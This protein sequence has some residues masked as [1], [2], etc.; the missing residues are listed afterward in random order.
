MNIETGTDFSIYIT[1][2]N[3]MFAS[4]VN[5]SGQCGIGSSKPQ[6]MAMIDYESQL[7]SLDPNSNCEII[8]IHSNDNSTI[9]RTSEGKLYGFGNHSYGC[10]GL[11]E[12][13][14]RENHEICRVGSGSKE[15]MKEKCISFSCGMFF[16]C[17]ITES[18]H[19]YA[20]GYNNCHQLS[21]KDLH[22]VYTPVKIIVFPIMPVIFQVTVD[23]LHQ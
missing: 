1:D 7:L 6:F 9:F 4:G 5:Y 11:G 13:I 12:D 22:T 15:F 16:V 3:K 21:A 23:L 14:E 20:F 19:L 8:E 17:A 18:N 2:D 10:F